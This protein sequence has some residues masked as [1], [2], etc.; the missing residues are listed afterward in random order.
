V[1]S[2][3]KEIREGASQDQPTAGHQDNPTSHKPEGGGLGDG[4]FMAWVEK[5]CQ[6]KRQQAQNYMA[7]AKL[8]LQRVEDL[9]IRG[10]LEEVTADKAKLAQEKRWQGS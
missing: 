2:T 4:Q 6:F 10:A 8:D 9:S 3:R 5:N 1:V 7:I